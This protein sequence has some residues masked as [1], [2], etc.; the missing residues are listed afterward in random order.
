MARP[1]KPEK[2]RRTKPFQIR[3]REDEHKTF[4]EAAELSGSDASH[5]ARTTLLREARKIIGHKPD[6]AKKETAV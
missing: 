4:T 1:K 3:L 5:W 2:N 6:E